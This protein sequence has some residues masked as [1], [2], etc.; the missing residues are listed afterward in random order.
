MNEIREDYLNSLTMKIFG[1]ERK[2]GECVACGK[3]VKDGDF[4]DELSFREYQISRMCQECQDKTFRE[5]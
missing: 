2:E 4:Q 3:E 5:D 1:R